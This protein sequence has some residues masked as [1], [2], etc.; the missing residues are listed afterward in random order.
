M[1]VIFLKDVPRVGRA[2]E[3]KEVAD[4]YARNFLFARKLAEPATA[5]K[6]EALKT[7]TAEHEAHR[8]VQEHLL[9]KNLETLQG[10]KLEIKSKANEQGHLFKGIHVKDIVKLLH[11]HGHV[12]L[13]E[14]H[15]LLEHPV[16]ELG[17]TQVPVEVA[18][19]KGEFT[20]LVT[21]EK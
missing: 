14:E 3:V 8:K 13:N 2:H 10:V 18:G 4:G 19:K 15:V 6:V 17:E 1:K 20:L 5:L 7:R 11:E 12:D 9:L 16:K 21:E